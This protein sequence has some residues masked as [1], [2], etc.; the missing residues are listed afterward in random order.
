MLEHTPGAVTQPRS[1][2]EQFARPT[3]FWGQIA[4]YLM[5]LTNQ[6][7]NRLVCQFL[8]VQPHDRVLEIGFGPG[9][10]IELL[11]PLVPQ[12][13][14]AGVDPSEV[15]VRQATRRNAAWIR[16]GRVALLHGT[17]SALP[18]RDREF[19]K[20][21]AVNSFYFWPRPLED[22]REVR[23]VLQD[24]GR[25]VLS[26]CGGMSQ[27]HACGS[28]R[29]FLTAPL[30]RSAPSWRRPAFGTLAATPLAPD[31]RR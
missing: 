18:W 23:R 16:A 14:V 13:L 10:L 24:G 7:V 21:C 26:A 28:R 30:R 9:R 1:F 3:G 5:A 22:L 15:M 6:P 8:D 20:A 19:S 31:G 25:L 4:G 12:G 2:R 11:A 27:G 17:V 29:A